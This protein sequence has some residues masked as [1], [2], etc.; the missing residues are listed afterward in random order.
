MIYLNNGKVGIIR[1]PT[2][3]RDRL[4]LSFEMAKTVAPNLK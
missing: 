1:K 3:N 4:L 2:N